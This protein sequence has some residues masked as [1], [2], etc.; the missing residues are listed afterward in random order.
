MTQ[1]YRAIATAEEGHISI[2]SSVLLN[3]QTDWQVSFGDS[4]KVL[5]ARRI[6]RETSKASDRE[7][8]GV[9]VVKDI[10]NSWAR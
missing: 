6:G 5:T 1:T 8:E 2:C 4:N 9:K 10:L 7:R 3:D